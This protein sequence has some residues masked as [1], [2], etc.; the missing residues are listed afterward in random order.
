[1]EVDDK[2]RQAYLETIADLGKR[3]GEADQRISELSH[4]RDEAKISVGYQR[5]SRRSRSKDLAIWNQQYV[6]REISRLRDALKAIVIESEDE[7]EIGGV[8]R[9]AQQA[10]AAAP[11][12]KL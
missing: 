1:M 3:L 11:E 10:L 4:E 7:Y 2:L 5:P 9:L 12:E 8:D 6:V